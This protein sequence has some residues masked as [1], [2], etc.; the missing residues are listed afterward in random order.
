MEIYIY[1]T[2]THLADAHFESELEC[3]PSTETSHRVLRLKV[4]G[5]RGLS[6][7]EF[8]VGLENSGWLRHIKAI[9]DAAI[10]LT[11]A[12]TVEGAS[13]LVHCS[14]GWDRTAQVC[15]LGSLLMDPY[16]RTIKGFMV[17]IEKDWI[18]FGHKFAD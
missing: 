7:T 15:S 14:D 18:S 16:Y 4:V 1:I 12:V 3:S 9:V 11:K 2:F 17:L 8:L 5:T 10:F 13:V 6:V